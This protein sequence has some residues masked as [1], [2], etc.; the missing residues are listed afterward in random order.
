MADP[1]PGVY[2]RL[3]SAFQA[4][5]APR[6]SKQLPRRSDPLC[7]SPTAPAALDREDS[8][9]SQ[10]G[11]LLASPGDLDGADS[12]LPPTPPTASQDGK[13]PPDPEQPRHADSVHNSL[14][15]QKSSLST[16]VNARS[17][18]TPDPSPPRT[19][20]PSTTL[21]RPPLYTHPSVRATSSPTAREDP[22]PSDREE[23]RLTTPAD[24]RLSTVEEAQ[25][26]GPR[27]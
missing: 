13:S 14:L 5:P 8:Y 10:D 17:P 22:F 24:D 1:E 27:F 9:T 16:P 23:T 21:E 2:V 26:T 18:P 19:N 15:S 12:G 4:A 3:E 7:S 11:T 25:R 20:G 6:Q